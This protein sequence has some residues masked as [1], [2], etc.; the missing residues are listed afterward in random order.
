M[1]IIITKIDICKNREEVMT[2]TILDLKKILKLPGIR[3][4]TYKINDKED[5][6]LASKNKNNNSRRASQ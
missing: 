1:A 5:I 2:N 3:R 6:L 4:M